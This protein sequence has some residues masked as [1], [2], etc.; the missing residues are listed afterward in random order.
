MFP[1]S[2]ATRRQDGTTMS[3]LLAAILALSASTAAAADRRPALHYAM[4]EGKD[5]TLADAVAG[6]NASVT[7]AEWVKNRHRS[8]LRF[9][10]SD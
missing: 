1:H 10:Q 5:V 4:A 9:N 3:T 7:D 2:R 8:S 6:H